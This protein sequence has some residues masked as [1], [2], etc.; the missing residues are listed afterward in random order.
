MEDFLNYIRDTLGYAPKSIVPGRITRFHT[1]NRTKQNGWCKL[2]LTLDYGV[3]GDWSHGEE[4]IYK[5]RKGGA[6]EKLSPSEKRELKKE[7]AKAREQEEKERK[8]LF[9]TM[10]KEA[11]NLCPITEEG[12]LSYLSRKGLMETHGILW[13]KEANALAFKFFNQ[14]GYLMGFQRIFP[15]G[16]KQICKGSRKKGAFA[17]VGYKRNASPKFACEGWATGCSIQEATDNNVI[18]CIDAGNL[19]EGIKSACS[20]YDISPTTITIIADNDSSKKGEEC[21][22]EAQKKLGVKVF[23][24]PILGYDA[25]DYAHEYGVVGLKK[26]LRGI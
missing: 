10:L 25:N 14:D 4:R 12:D 11:D 3:F 19:T 18:V 1:E 24:M 2:F 22:L 8:A 13:D 26:L 16:S 5:W 15:N 6:T 21:A 23:I 9:E 20:Y 17:I 7:L